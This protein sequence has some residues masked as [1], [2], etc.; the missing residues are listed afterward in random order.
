VKGT[1]ALFVIQGRG[2]G[3]FGAFLTRDLKLSGRQNG[4]PFGI[5]FL[6][7]EAVGL[8]HDNLLWASLRKAGA[9]GCREDASHAGLDDAFAIAR[10]H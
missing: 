9:I 10:M 8:G 2:E 6:D 7:G 3:A 4:L 1:V 5:G